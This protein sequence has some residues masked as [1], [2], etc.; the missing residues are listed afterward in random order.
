MIVEIDDGD[1]PPLPEIAAEVWVRQPL[2]YFVQPGG[3]VLLHES[4]R[5]PAPRY[6]FA[7]LGP[8]LPRE[9]AVAARLGPAE[10]SARPAEAPGWL[11]PVALGAAVGGAAGGARAGAAPGSRLLAFR[12]WALFC[13]RTGTI[14]L[15]AAKPRPAARACSPSSASTARSCGP[16]PCTTGPIPLSCWW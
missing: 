5:L 1:N 7:S 10:E 2:L 9:E 12:H 6:D 8:G 15:T 16:G 14:R 11:L 4:R 3:R 13:H